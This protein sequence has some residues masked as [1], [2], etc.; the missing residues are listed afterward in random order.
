MSF[1]KLQLY[2]CRYNTTK[3]VEKIRFCE[4][5]KWMYFLPQ[6]QFICMHDDKFKNP[7]DFKRF[8][9]KFI[10][11]NHPDY[12]RYYDIESSSLKFNGMPLISESD[13]KI[14]ND[15]NQQ[16]MIRL[17]NEHQ[18]SQC[19]CNNSFIASRIIRKRHK[20]TVQEK[21]EISFDLGRGT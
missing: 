9:T 11:L 1:L 7:V 13:Y 20:L 8:H 15:A 17:R 2:Y 10:N 5:D 21:L 16:D 19:H 12:L 4:K 14:Y 3:L 6:D 18:L